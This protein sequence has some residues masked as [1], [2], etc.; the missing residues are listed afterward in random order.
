MMQ[1][2]AAAFVK[3]EYTVNRKCC[4]SCLATKASHL[5]RTWQTQAVSHTAM[6]SCYA[7][8]YQ[9]CARSMLHAYRDSI[10]A[11]ARHLIIKC[12]QPIAPR[13]CQ[14]L[15]HKP[16][17]H[18]LRHQKTTHLKRIPTAICDVRASY[19]RL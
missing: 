12:K 11:S 7:Q 1:H 19:L 14:P 18:L 2:Q 4:P 5:M 10:A 9:H 13:Q 17:C 15:L 16:L 8:I 3:I 6:I